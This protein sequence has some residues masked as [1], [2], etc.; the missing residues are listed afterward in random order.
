M[1]NHLE[2]ES[3]I[4]IHLLNENESYAFSQEVSRL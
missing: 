4:E 1:Q 3:L 2:G